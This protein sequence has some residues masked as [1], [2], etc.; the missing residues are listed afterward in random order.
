MAKERAYVALGSVD[1]GIISKPERYVIHIRDS[2][3]SRKAG[4]QPPSWPRS[5]YANDEEKLLETDSGGV[6]GASVGMG[7]DVLVASSWRVSE[8]SLGVG[9]V[10]G[11][12]DSCV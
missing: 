10:L 11:L 6:S 9:N 1:L 5:S 8:V 12:P 3:S 2:K 4:G 7:S